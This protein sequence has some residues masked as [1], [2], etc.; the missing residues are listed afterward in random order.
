MNLL[1]TKPVPMTYISYPAADPPTIVERI[2]THEGTTSYV[3]IIAT[4][5]VGAIIQ[6]R[7]L[8]TENSR[9]L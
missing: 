4:Y 9:R 6:A 5:N 3:S 7:R 8:S 2:D 1:N